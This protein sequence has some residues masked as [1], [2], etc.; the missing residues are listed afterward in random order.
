MASPRGAIRGHRACRLGLQVSGDMEDSA[1]G[2]RLKQQSAASRDAI[3][4]DPELTAWR[5]SMRD[6]VA[7]QNSNP[8]MAPRHSGRAET[9]PE[10]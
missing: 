6:K 8:A 5:R 9:E 10:P 2:R 1:V 7:A 4:E 3:S